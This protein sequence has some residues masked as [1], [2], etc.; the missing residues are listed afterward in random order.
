MNRAIFSTALTAAAI[1]GLAGCSA[2]ASSTTPDGQMP[3]NPPGA[4]TSAPPASTPAAA[5]AL[6]VVMNFCGK[7]TPA[8][9]AGIGQ[10]WNSGAI[11]T[12]TNQTHAEMVNPTQVDVD[13]MQGSFVRGS[14]VNGMV[15]ALM[16][17]QSEQ[18]S[19]GNSDGSQ[20]DRCQVTGYGYTSGG[21]WTEVS[22]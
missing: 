5:Q 10:G 11:L 20:S 12:I 18:V 22:S 7:F 17:G 1:A 2:P 3:V 21:Q 6:K 9:K 13:F 16:P 8:Q 14:D 19:V 4:V 15:S